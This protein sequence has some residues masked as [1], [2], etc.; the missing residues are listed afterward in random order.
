MN[1]DVLGKLEKSAFM[2]TWTSSV[3]N[4]KSQ[5]ILF[6]IVLL[7]IYCSW[8]WERGCVKINSVGWNNFRNLWNI[9]ISSLF[10]KKTLIVLN[11]K[12]L[13]L[14]KMYFAGTDAQLLDSKDFAI[15]D[16]ISMNSPIEMH[17]HPLFQMLNLVVALSLESFTLT[18]CKVGNRIPRSYMEKF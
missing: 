6:C 13:Q 16:Y 17:G 5:T 1:Q 11:S 14:N 8:M 7:V 18:Q 3:F 10:E 9:S 4:S 15:Q 2:W 12:N